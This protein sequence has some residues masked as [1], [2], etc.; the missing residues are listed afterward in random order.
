VFVSALGIRHRTVLPYRAQSNGLVERKTATIL[1][2]AC[3]QCCWSASIPKRHGQT[4]LQQLFGSSM[5]QRV[6]LL[7]LLVNVCL[8]AQQTAANRR[9]FNGFLVVG[10]TSCAFNNSKHFRMWVTSNI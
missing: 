2:F 8:G 6:R 4:S 5:T 3:A 1:Q 7:C 10:K 9:L